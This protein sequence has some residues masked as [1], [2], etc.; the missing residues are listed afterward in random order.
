MSPVKILH[1]GASQVS[2]Y[3]A[4]SFALVSPS[5]SALF[6]IAVL[7]VAPLIRAPIAPSEPP[8]EE[9]FVCWHFTPDLTTLANFGIAYDKCGITPYCPTQWFLL[10]Y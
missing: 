6:F 10:V 8:H 1:M 4:L 3:C 5:L 9:K 2:L 7:F